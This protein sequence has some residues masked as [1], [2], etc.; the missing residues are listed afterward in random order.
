MKL[1]RLLF[2]L[3]LFVIILVL[4]NVLL[5]FYLTHG[6]IHTLNDYEK[7]DFDYKV[8]RQ[9]VEVLWVLGR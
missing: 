7:F 1:P 4:L 8:S 5:M 2:Y 9:G 6:R 3:F